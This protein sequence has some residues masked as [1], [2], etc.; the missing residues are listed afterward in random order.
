[1]F[2]EATKDRPACS[3]FVLFLLVSAKLGTREK[4]GNMSKVFQFK[5]V[6]LGESAVGK[7]S[8]VLRF[9]KGQFLEYQES[10]IGGEPALCFLLFVFL[11][12]VSGASFFPIHARSKR[13]CPKLY[14]VLMDSV[15]PAQDSFR[16][17]ESF[18][19]SS[20]FFF[21]FSPFLSL[22]LLPTLH[23][24]SFLSLFSHYL[25]LQLPS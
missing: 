12:F 19:S 7:S 9:V 5:L 3:L 13:C 6:L 11:P 25:P 20:F 23:V 21:G 14:S 24:F 15:K 10:T 4:G 18:F 1:L 16:V 2:E 22:S 8:L 17:S